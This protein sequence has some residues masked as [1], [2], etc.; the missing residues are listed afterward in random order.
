MF[1]Q[2]DVEL[3]RSHPVFIGINEQPS[4]KSKFL[5]AP[6]PGQFS[7]EINTLAKKSNEPAAV[8]IF[9]RVPGLDLVRISLHRLESI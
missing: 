9:D 8:A 7:V 1:A 5:S 3:N 6:R 4:L 2:L